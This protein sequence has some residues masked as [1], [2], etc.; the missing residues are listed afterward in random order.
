[1]VENFDDNSIT[2][3]SLEDSG[4]NDLEAFKVLE[5]VVGTILKYQAS[6]YIVFSFSPTPGSADP[7]QSVSIYQLT[8]SS[9]CHSGLTASRK[10]IISELRP[11]LEGE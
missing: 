4:L 3:A 2:S 5:A 9:T 7:K 8:V 1:V 11:N 6:A 10:R